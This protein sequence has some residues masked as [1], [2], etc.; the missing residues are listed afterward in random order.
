M[1]DSQKN[2]LKVRIFRNTVIFQD[3]AKVFFKMI[4]A[5]KNNKPDK[6]LF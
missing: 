2:I 4:Y 5:K 3:I 1:E 6:T